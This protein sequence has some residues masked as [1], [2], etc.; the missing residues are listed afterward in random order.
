MG[1]FVEVAQDD[2]RAG[3]VR[4]PEEM[5]IHQDAFDANP[6]IQAVALVNIVGGNPE[7]VHG[8]T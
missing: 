3:N 2:A 8:Y 6:A 4:R 5:F 7:A 1:P